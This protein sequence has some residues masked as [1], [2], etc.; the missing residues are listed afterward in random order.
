VNVSV[1]VVA[2]DEGS[3]PQK[4]D[5]GEEALEVTFG[6]SASGVGPLLEFEG[7]SRETRAQTKSSRAVSDGAAA[8]IRATGGSIGLFKQNAGPFRGRPVFSFRILNTEFF[9]SDI[10]S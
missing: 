3:V 8:A 9:A 7:F 5:A 10:L 6:V 2:R 4:D 1:L